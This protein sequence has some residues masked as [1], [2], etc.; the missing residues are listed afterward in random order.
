MN[1]FVAE[2]PLQYWICRRNGWFAQHRSK[3]KG[4]AALILGFPSGRSIGD[5][6]ALF[7]NRPS[8]GWVESVF[9]LAD[10]FFAVDL[11]VMTPLQRL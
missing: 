1:F 10:H 8:G 9:T 2:R 6:A 11:L 5:V 7:L 3:N 4:N